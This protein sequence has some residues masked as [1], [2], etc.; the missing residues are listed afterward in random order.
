MIFETAIG[1][2]A[3]EAAHAVYRFASRKRAFA[4]AQARSK[5]TGKPLVVI[6]DPDAG[7]HTRLIR[8]YGCGDVCIDLHGCPKCPDQLAADITKPLPF[9]DDSV[10]VFVSCVLEYVDDIEAAWREL[11]RVAGD[12][13]FVVRVHPWSLTSRCFPGAK[14]VLSPGKATRISD[15]PR[16]GAG[17]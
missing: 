7:A 1:I 3:Y 9:E 4:A 12:D 14:W 6:G 11:R 2:A 8:A 16:T 10:V 5:S 17:L 13:L 15:D